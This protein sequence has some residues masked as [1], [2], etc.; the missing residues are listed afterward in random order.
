MSIAN[1]KTRRAEPRTAADL[2]ARGFKTTTLPRTG[3]RGLYE[4]VREFRARVPQAYALVPAASDARR[5]TRGGKSHGLIVAHGMGSRSEAFPPLKSGGGWARRPMGTYES[6][7]AA[8][9]ALLDA[10][11]IA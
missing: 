8:A 11:G 6:V 2:T 10:Q 1:S 5:R 3:Q 7:V 9:H 4:S